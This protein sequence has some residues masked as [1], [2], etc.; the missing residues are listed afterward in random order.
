MTCAGHSLSNMI[1]KATRPSTTVGE[2]LQVYI[3]CSNNSKS[4]ACCWSLLH[5]PG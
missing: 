4:K 3:F 1:V 2:A 5:S